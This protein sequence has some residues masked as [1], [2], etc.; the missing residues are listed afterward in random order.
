MNESNEEF[1]G[2]RREEREAEGT[3]MKLR[4][5]ERLVQ[6]QE[7]MDSLVQSYDSGVRDLLTAFA[8]QSPEMAAYTVGGPEELGRQINWWIEYTTV[9]KPTKK[10]IL[11]VL[12]YLVGREGSEQFTPDCFSVEGLTGVTTVRPPTIEALR[13]TLGNAVFRI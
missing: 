13:E 12:R 9:D 4:E 10:T 8:R 1:F 5:Q 7:R 3:A 6:W 2:R 11:V